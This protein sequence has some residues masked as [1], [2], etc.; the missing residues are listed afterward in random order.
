MINKLFLSLS[1][2][3]L[4]SGYCFAQPSLVQNDPQKQT[5]TFGNSK[6]KFVLNYDHQCRVSGMDVNGQEVMDGPT[7]MY[8]AIK[9]IDKTFSTLQLATSPRVQI[10]GNTID[11]SG[12]TY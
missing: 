5:V 7:G 12:I 9:T 4:S 11:I 10:T 6:V 3:I 1:A 8:S 2:I